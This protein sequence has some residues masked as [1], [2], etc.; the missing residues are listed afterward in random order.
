MYIYTFLGKGLE[1]HRR[2]LWGY[3]FAGQFVC[4]HILYISKYVSICLSI[5][6]CICIYIYIYIYIYMCIYTY[7]SLPGKGLG[8]ERGI[9]RGDHFAGQFICPYIL[10]ISKYVSNCLFIYLYVYI[11]IYIYIYLYIYICVCVCVCIY[12]YSSLPGEGLGV[13]R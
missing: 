12:T 11:Y 8:V 7:S 13:E 9:R 6:R 5:Y 3:H 4:L 1:V 2:I 10:C